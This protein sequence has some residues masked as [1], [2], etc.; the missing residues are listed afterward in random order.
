MPP[1]LRETGHAK[2]APIRSFES[3]LRG[4]AWINPWHNASNEPRF[5]TELDDCEE[6]AVLLE[7]IES[8]L[9]LVDGLKQEDIP[10]D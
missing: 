9:A 5:L 3:L 8:F 1:L 10:L 4:R 6:R 7:R 2:P